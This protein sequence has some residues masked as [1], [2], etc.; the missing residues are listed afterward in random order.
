MPNV[1]VAEQEPGA[2]PSWFRALQSHCRGHRFEP[3]CPYLF[4]KK[5]AAFHIRR[6][7]DFAL[8]YMHE[9]SP[10]VVAMAVSTEMSM[11]ITI[12]QVSFF[13]LILLSFL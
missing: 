6:V 13:I 7:A 5:S 9:V 10:K 1:A 11:L 12:F 4:K 2:S 3:D 8:C